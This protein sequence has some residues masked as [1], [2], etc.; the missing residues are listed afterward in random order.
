LDTLWL[1]PAVS[2]LAR[3]TFLQIT[4]AISASET[5]EELSILIHGLLNGSSNVR[6]VVLQSL[7]SFDLEDCE[8]SEILFL[9]LHD[10]D[11]RNAELATDLSE[12]NSISL[13]SYDLEKL[14][15]LLGSLDAFISNGRT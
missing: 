2:K 11:E 8:N 9:A 12:H 7:E 13:K 6:S 14:F 5:K 1:V 15:S 3:D 4:D 10:A